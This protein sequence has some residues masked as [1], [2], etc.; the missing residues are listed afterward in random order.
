MDIGFD[1]IIQIH[2]LAAETWGLVSSW[3]WTLPPLVLIGIGFALAQIRLQ[4][5]NAVL[6]VSTRTVWLCAGILILAI[7]VLS[8]LSGSPALSQFSWDFGGQ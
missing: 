7:L 8:I 2:N 6:T 5:I 3:L 4:T 1:T